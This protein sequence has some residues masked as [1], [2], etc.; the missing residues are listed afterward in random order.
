MMFTGPK[1]DDM[2][3]S[4][5]GLAV[6]SKKLNLTQFNTLSTSVETRCNQELTTLGEAACKAYAVG[7]VVTLHLRIQ[8]LG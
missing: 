1:R 5:G 4:K 2:I 8:A 3:R 7:G 6:R